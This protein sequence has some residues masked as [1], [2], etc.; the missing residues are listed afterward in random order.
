MR[1][2]R[3]WIFFEGMTMSVSRSLLA[4]LLVVLAGALSAK[5]QADAV[6][7]KPTSDQAEAARLA[8]RYLTRMHYKPTEIDDTLSRQ[9][10]DAYIESLDGNKWFFVQS[11]IDEF[12]KYQTTLDD[13][14]KQDDLDPAF[15]IFRRYV[16]RVAERVTFARETLKKPFDFGVDESIELDRSEEPWARDRAALDDLWR[17][18]VKNDALQLRISKTSRNRAD[19]NK[20]APGTKPSTSA[21]GPLPEK[22]DEKKPIDAQIRETLDKRYADLNRR[23]RDLNSEDVFQNFLNAFAMSIEPHTNY[24]GPRASENFQIQM[25]LS[26][27]GIGAVLQPDSDYTVV[28]EVVKG[29]PADMSGKIRVG[30]R[31]VGVAQG[32]TASIV[33]VVG[34]RLDD[35]V[36]LI[37]G[38]KGTMVKLEVL[39]KDVGTGGP[40]DFVVIQRDKVKLEQQAAKSRVINV[41]EGNTTRVIGIIE[42]PTFYLDFAARARGDADYRSSTR[43]VRRLIE[44]LKAK[45]VD[46][47]VMDLRDNGG[48]SLDEA[49]ELTGLFIDRGPVVQ[50]KGVGMGIEV[51]SDRDAGAV[52]MGPFA[53]LVNRSS[54]SAS[55]IF[56]AA[57]QDYGRGLILGDNTFGKG[58]V[59]N[60]I[61]LDQMGNEEK[62]RF[63]Q[64]KITMAQFFRIDGGSTQLRGVKPD[65]VFP[66]AYDA[67]DFGET[68]YDNALPWSSIP[69][70]RY[71]T[72]GDFASVIPTLNERHLKR[73]AGD[74]EF[75]YLIEDINDYRAARDDT[76]VSLL[77]S[78]RR[79]EAKTEESKREAREAERDKAKAQDRALNPPV[80]PRPVSPSTSGVAAATNPPAETPD[81]DEQSDVLL[82]EAA[83]VLSDFIELKGDKP[84]SSTVVAKSEVR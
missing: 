21:T 70:S 79:A 74:R 12:S 81:S 69:P 66:S 16:E 13:S 82:N 27:E 7:L 75:Q 78:K 1:G 5:P 46:G 49:T 53:V 24:M 11:D 20:P 51:K 55:E 17:K 80:D 47:I 40:T 59:Q 77:E 38:P 30:D 29:G 10:F 68:A 65:I 35:V 71:R 58:T 62:P 3:K 50:I 63:G 67:E 25:R 18:R 19:E 14:L 2:C 23:V 45:R 36:E 83:H 73:I 37:R 44:E 61:D 8:T 9:M 54:A 76:K 72:Y 43:D 39:P 4:T 26:L 6:V 60:L 41:R 32:Q 84:S 48:G 56:A 64:V 57:I 28:R 52:W 31:I 22:V 34:W 15:V 42:L 33:D